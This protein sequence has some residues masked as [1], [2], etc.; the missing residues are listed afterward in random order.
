MPPTEVHQRWQM[1]FKTDILLTSDGLV[2][3][4]G[5]RD[6]VGE[7]CIDGLLYATQLVNLRVPRVTIEEAQATLRHSFAR[8]NTLPDEVQTDNEATLVNS[9]PD[10]FPNLFTLW[11]V[12]L[13][14]R[15]RFTRPG[16]PTDNAEIE[17]CHRTVNDYAIVGNE[18]HSRIELQR[19]LDRAV[20][21]LAYELP[22]P[23]RRLPRPATH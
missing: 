10:E 1:D 13:G 4:H 11:L 14:V 19:I 15:H 16:H 2:V 5:V 22:S 8:W 20:D 12:G 17:R 9:G 21:E 7:V 3:L 23:G 18:R 6:P